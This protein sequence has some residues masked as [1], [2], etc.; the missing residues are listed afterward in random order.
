MADP[1]AAIDPPR[2][3]WVWLALG[4]YLVSFV[5]PF[6]VEGGSLLYGY[7]AFGYSLVMLVLGPV[8]GLSGGWDGWWL[9]IAVAGIPWLANPCFWWCLVCQA[10]DQRRLA[11][12]LGGLAIGFGLIGRLFG[13]IG[14]RFPAYWVWLVSFAIPLIGLAVTLAQRRR[15][16]ASSAERSGTCGH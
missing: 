13:S 9:M 11:A 15:R 3:P 7:H 16:S 5:V 14:P 1:Y 12:T 8:I 4:I 6:G 2:G 10:E